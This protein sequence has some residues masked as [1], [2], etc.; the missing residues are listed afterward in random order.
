[1]EAAV[2]GQRRPGGD[3]AFA[4]VLTVRA[5]TQEAAVSLLDFLEPGWGVS[6]LPWH[7]AGQQ[8][9]LVQ[10][11][12]EDAL[13]RVR[14]AAGRRRRVI[15]WVDRLWMVSAGGRVQVRPRLPVRSAED[16]ALVYTPGVGRLA[17]AIAARPAAAVEVTGRPNRVA[18]VSDGTAVL[19]LGDVGPLAALPVMEGKAALFAQLADIDAVPICLDAGDPDKVV[20]AVRT[21]A[22]TFGGINLAD[23][24]APACFDIER[25]LQ[26][27]LDIPVFHDDQHGTAVVVLAGLRNALR[28]VGKQLETAR[29][30]V[31]GAGAAGTAVARLLLRAGASDVTVWARQGVLGPHLDELPAHKVWLAEHT[32]PRRIRSGLAHALVGADAVVGVSR[33]GLLSS[34]MVAEMALR[35]VVFALANP[36]P[37]IR[38]EML[39]GLDPVIATGRCDYPNHISNAL[40]FPGVFR[41]ALNARA[42]RITTAMLLAAADVLAGL[43]G[44]ELL[45]PRR[46]LPDVLD[47]QVVPTVAAA[48]AAVEASR[49]HAAEHA[50]DEGWIDE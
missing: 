37:E 47:P 20:A 36:E 7:V 48:V 16:L 23:I 40:V 28:V 26:D 49:H 2:E 10:V 24:A 42:P 27:V 13:R 50:G 45:G 3:P 1:M 19:G 29:I 32:N 30:V 5:D 43:V 6:V 4:A 9:L 34:Q 39:A 46:L 14:Q 41:G 15:G 44:K 22:P 21:L 38:P 25:R 33:G 11:D 8:R 31:M 17:A 12:G 18:V 35:P